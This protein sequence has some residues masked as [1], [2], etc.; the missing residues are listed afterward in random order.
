MRFYGARRNGLLGDRPDLLSL[1]AF[2]RRTI[3]CALRRGILPL[4]AV[5]WLALASVGGVD[6]TRH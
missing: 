6:E 1:V 4:L 3:F 5:H 2:H